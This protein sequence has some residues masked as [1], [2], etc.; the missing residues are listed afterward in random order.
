MKEFD[1]LFSFPISFHQMTE[2]DHEKQT[3]MFYES[4]SK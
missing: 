4:E 1:H 3:S 2:F